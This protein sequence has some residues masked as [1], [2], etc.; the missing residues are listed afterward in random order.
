MRNELRTEII[1]GD[2]YIPKFSSVLLVVQKGF[3]VEWFL[4]QWQESI[5][6]AVHVKQIGYHNDSHLTDSPNNYFLFYLFSM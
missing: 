6:Y 3:G 1:T 2:T 4:V 5:F